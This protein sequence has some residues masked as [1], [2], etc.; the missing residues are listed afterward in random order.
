EQPDAAELESV[1]QASRLRQQ[2]EH[3][4][5]QAEIVRLGERVQSRQRIGEAEQA[6]GSRE[7]KERARRDG[8]DCHDVERDSHARSVDLAPSGWRGGLPFLAKA[9]EA[10]VARSA[11][12][13]APS[14]VAGTPV[15]APRS[16]N[17]AMPPV[18]ISCA[19]IMRSASP[20]PRRMRTSPSASIA[21][22]K[23]RAAVRKSVMTE[24]ARQR[25]F[26]RGELRHN[27]LVD[28]EAVVD[29]LS[30]LLPSRHRAG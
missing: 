28:V 30:A 12:V 29:E 2:P 14:T 25:P 6:D 13:K 21:R 27:R 23:P 5:T 24:R 19:A 15:T 22:M 4:E 9:M 1:A 20:G 10:K 11:S 8:H 17:A 3:H 7:E 16:S 26:L 18:P